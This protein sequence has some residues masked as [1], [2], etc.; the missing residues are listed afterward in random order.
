M[1]SLTSIVFHPTGPA[2]S[3]TKFFVASRRGRRMHVRSAMDWL[4][5]ALVAAGVEDRHDPT[6]ITLVSG[7]I[8]KAVSSYGREHGDPGVKSGIAELMQHSEA[9]AEAAYY[10]DEAGAR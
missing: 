2:S 4:R 6:F 5:R 8:R 1:P 3:E 9:T 10:V 7:A